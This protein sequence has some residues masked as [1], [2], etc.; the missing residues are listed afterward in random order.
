MG[1]R[2]SRCSSALTKR[3][4]MTGDLVA[5]AGCGRTPCACG[6]LAKAM[7]NW[8]TVQPAEP[9]DVPSAED[10]PDAWLMSMPMGQSTAITGARD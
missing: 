8:Q 9:D 1:G 10:A 2:R 3:S 5:G 6:T 4:R 7:Q